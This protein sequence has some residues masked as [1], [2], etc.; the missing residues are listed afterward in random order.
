MGPAEWLGGLALFV[1]IG[2]TVVLLML[3]RHIAGGQPALRE[4]HS[5]PI[6]AGLPVF[7]VHARDGSVVDDARACDHV[8]LFLGATCPSCHAVAAE[9]QTSD[10]TTLPKLLIAVVDRS[11]DT[12]PNINERLQGVHAAAI[13]DDPDR[14]V[15]NRLAVPGTPFAYAIDADGTVRGKQP[16]TSVDRIRSLARHV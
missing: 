7:S 10:P 4:K 13:F 2:N 8:L 5:L 14:L 6:G 16:A 1:G 9:L 12:E 11:A 15:A 3:L